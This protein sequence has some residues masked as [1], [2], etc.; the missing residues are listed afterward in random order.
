MKITAI[1]LAGGLSR[2][3]KWNKL[4]LQTKCFWL[5]CLGIL[6]PDPSLDDFRLHHVRTSIPSSRNMQRSLSPFVPLIGAAR[7]NLLFFGFS[8]STKGSPSPVS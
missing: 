6:A 4:A 5:I 2:R 3:I 8:G 7:K 1:I